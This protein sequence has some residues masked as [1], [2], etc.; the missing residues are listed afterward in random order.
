[1]VTRPQR[2]GKGAP[3]FKALSHRAKIT[4][5][6]PQY[7]E[8]T[9][10][11]VI[12]DIIH[13]FMHKAPIAEVLL[14]NGEVFYIPAPLG[15]YTGMKIQ[16]GPNAEVSVGN[17]LPLKNIPEGTEIFMIEKIPNDGGKFVRSAGL[18]A[19]I[20]GK[21]GKRIFVQLPSR[22]IIELNEKCRAVIGVVAGG[23]KKEKPLVK[24]GTAYYVKRLKLRKVWP[25][26]AAK[27]M[28]AADHPMGGGK[29]RTH[30]P[31]TVSKRAPRGAKFG[32]IGAR[33]TGRRKK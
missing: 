14:E 30:R 1:M 27:A 13:H 12:R 8:E 20:V 9:I 32:S 7:S 17:I 18:C 25:H 26:V 6:F 33:R 21:E 5:K 24:A 31:K 15:A 29:R 11:G 19:K 22:K 28:V 4:I 23:G 2:R 10:N 16:I 3:R